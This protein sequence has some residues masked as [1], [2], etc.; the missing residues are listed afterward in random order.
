MVRIDLHTHSRASDGTQTP[1]ELVRAAVRAGLDVVALTDH[2]TAAGWA[3][4]AA[5]GGGRG[6]P[7]GA[8][9]G[10]QHPAPRSRRAPARL[11]AG[12]GRT[13]PCATRP[14]PDPRGPRVTGAGHGR[15][16]ARARHRGHR[17][18]RRRRCRRAAATGRPHVADALVPW[19]RWPTATRPSTLSWPPAARLRRPVRR[20]AH[21]DDRPGRRGRR[22]QR[23]RPPLGPPR[24]D[25][26]RRGGAGRPGRTGAGRPGGRPRGPRPG[27]PGEAPRRRRRPGPGRH[28]LQRPPRRRARSAT[29]LGCDT[30]D[31]AEFDR[32]LDGATAPPPRPAGPC[33][34]W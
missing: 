27:D 30:T 9:H 8:R 18:R 14:R 22:G 29:H 6:C 13:R 5:A 31:P 4:A 34:R 20:A 19:A 15:G 28:R 21:R 2:D 26:P 10:D 32:L 7:A 1:A 25:Q 12:P 23:D 11:P 3:E 17:R 24:A 16:P 33:P